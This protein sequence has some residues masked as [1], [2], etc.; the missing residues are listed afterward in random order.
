MSKN[1]NTINPLPMDALDMENVNPNLSPRQQQV[2]AA[3]PVM[4]QIPDLHGKKTTPSINEGATKI[5]LDV[6]IQT[7]EDD[8]ENKK[9]YFV[10]LPHSGYEF[11]VR[12]L[13]VEEEDEI[14]SS[15]TSTKRAAETIMKVLYK[16]ISNDIK[17][18]DHP[19]GRFDTFCKN[20]SIADRDAIALAVIEKTYESTHDMNIRCARCGKS[21]NETITLPECMTYKFYT[22][23]T[24]L[25][26][27]RHVL[28][29]PE[30]KWKM[31]LKIPTLYDELK[32]LNSNEKN[33]DIQR[34][35]EYI[36][37]DKLEYQD[38]TDRDEIVN[39][40]LTNYVQI[41]AMLKKQP[42]IIR[43]RIEKEYEKFRG[44]YGVNGQYETS[45]QY[46]DSP[47]L[48]NIIPITHFLFLV[49]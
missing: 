48:V 16:C 19:F 39:D 17:T 14:K 35:T 2:I 21:F 38:K 8:T 26:Q 34:A 24:P 47:I 9:Q 42:A 18:K 37:I 33:D 27:K 46:C 3:T 20:I 7:P 40:V 11:N 13:L 4:Q 41:Y 1:D 5:S 45:C 28:E 10:K 30:L 15:N 49:Q 31:Y 36:Y 32:T 44:D 29:F 12:G 22:G 6:R 23:T 25:L 43:K